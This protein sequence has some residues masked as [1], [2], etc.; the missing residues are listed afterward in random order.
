MNPAADTESQSRSA[1]QIFAETVL[2]SLTQ[3]V[4]TDPRF[5]RIRQMY[6]AL[7]LAMWYKT[8]FQSSLIGQEFVD[9]QWTQGL[10]PLTNTKNSVEVFDQYMEDIRQGVFNGVYEH[11]QATDQMLHTIEYVSGGVMYQNLS[12]VV[13]QSSPNQL[14]NLSI[15][16]SINQRIDQ[17]NQSDQMERYLSFPHSISHFNPLTL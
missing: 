3:I 12:K 17:E 16:Q 11:Y 2:P 5:L 7:I 4:Q 13:Q 9:Q 14:N 6:H 8:N 15:N 1:D 10:Q